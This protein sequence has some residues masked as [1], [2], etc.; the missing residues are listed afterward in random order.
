MDFDIFFMTSVI[1]N[2]E[3][4]YMLLD[5]I[6]PLFDDWRRYLYEI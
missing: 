6:L 1:L 2:T 4:F 5:D 3:A